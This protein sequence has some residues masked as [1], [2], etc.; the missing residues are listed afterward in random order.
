MSLW[1]FDPQSK[2]IGVSNTRLTTAMDVAQHKT[3]NGLKKLWNELF[4][5]QLNHNSTVRVWSVSCPD[6]WVNVKR[7]ATHEHVRAAH[8]HWALCMAMWGLSTPTG[9]PAWPCEGCPLPLGTLLCA[10]PKTSWF[11][12][13]KW[14]MALLSQVLTLATSGLYG[15][16]RIWHFLN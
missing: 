14:Q 3:S 12:V 8:S 10:E 7:M 4:I 5:K 2:T 16:R 11:I 9:H 15:L 1:A 13:P 6:D